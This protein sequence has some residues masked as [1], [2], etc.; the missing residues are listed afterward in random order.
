[1]PDAAL[2]SSPDSRSLEIPK[3][4]PAKTKR[5]RRKRKLSLDITRCSG[6]IPT[7]IHSSIELA[8]K[9]ANYYAHAVNDDSMTF[10]ERLLAICSPHLE[11][12]LSICHLIQNNQEKNVFG[13]FHH[14][15]LSFEQFV[16]LMRNIQILSPD[17]VI[18]IISCNACQI[19]DEYAYMAIFH[20]VGTVFCK[21]NVL[22]TADQD[23]QSIQMISA[24]EKLMKQE[25]VQ[26]Q[27]HD[28][29]AVGSLTLRRKRNEK[30][31]R[32]EFFYEYVN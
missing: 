19:G 16:A 24:E 23:G 28:Y 27:L 7:E 2:V 25:N 1:M 29:Q 11:A 26:R 6:S 10:A 13:K 12:E 9:Y 22:L 20:F 17:S 18:K 31:Y 21:D 15:S 30:I 5:K 4:S 8:S 3:D 32:L 14:V